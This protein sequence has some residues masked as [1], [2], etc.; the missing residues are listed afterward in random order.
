[1][2]AEEGRGPGKRILIVDDSVDTARMMRLLLKRE[3]YDTRAAF[4]GPEA[5]E[6]A[7]SYLPDVVLLDLT[8]PSMGGAEVAAELRKVEGLAEL[9][10]IAITGYGQDGAPPACDRLL[11]KPVDHEVLMKLLA[12]SAAR[13]RVAGPLPGTLNVGA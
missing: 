5:I 11:V 3:G 4:D 13:P 8:L 6:A 7:R 2:R 12:D 10:I 1:M 9:T